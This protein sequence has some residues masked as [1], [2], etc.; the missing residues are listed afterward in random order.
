M[1]KIS[2][3]EQDLTLVNNSE[4]LTDVVYV[5]GYAITGPVNTPVLC[6]TLSDFQKLFGS[7]PYRFEK[8]ERYSE[9]NIF[10]SK[11]YAPNSFIA[12]KDEY[13][14]SY[15]YATELLNKGLPILFERVMINSENKIAKLELTGNTIQYVQ[16]TPESNYNNELTYYSLVPFTGE[17]FESG[18]NYYV[19]D[20]DVY[21][22]TSD[23]TPQSKVNY[24]SLFENNLVNIT[25]N[26]TYYTINSSN[27]N[28]LDKIDL[29]STFDANTN[30]YIL[31]EDKYTQVAISDLISGNTYYI[32]STISTDSKIIIKA[33]YPGKYGKDIKVVLTKNIDNSYTL[34]A[35][36]NNTV[37]EITFVL[38]DTT[39][40]NYFMNYNNSPL[41][42]ITLE[43]INIS[44]NLIFENI[45]KF[46]N[47][48]TSDFDFT[49]NDLYQKFCGSSLEVSI[50]DKLKDRNAYNVK[51]I[52]T[53]GY[54]SL[55]VDSEVYLSNITYP[56][57]TDTIS[58][59]NLAKALLNIA[60]VRGS[61]A[62]IDHTNYSTRPL[63]GEDSVYYSLN[64]DTKEALT[65]WT[66]AKIKIGQKADLEDCRPS[67]TI[68]SPWY[69]Y[70]SKLFNL[71]IVMPGSFGY[72][73]ALAESIKTNVDWLAIAGV[74]RG[75]V[76]NVKQLTQDITSA[77][78]EEW[79]NEKGISIN[80]IT[81]INPYGYTIWGN[82]TLND[83]KHELVAT[84]F[85]NCRLLITEVKRALYNAA[86][87]YMFEN[88][89]NVLWVNFKSLVEKTLEKMV[90]NNGLQRYSVVK[91]VSKERATLTATVTIWLI[92]PIEK[93][94]LTVNIT[95]SYVNIE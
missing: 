82:R 35:S 8:N 5:P 94:D 59:N 19:L 38:D 24:F 87:K 71:N 12:Q 2:I 65:L 58:G 13:E 7:E 89:N 53:G 55:E 84:S 6:T 57:I 30:Y 43:F 27:T 14:Q 52:T 45:N 69:I 47:Y 68:L 50:F 36:L 75:L 25:T 60:L 74:S 83:N 15:I 9:L 93:F 23:S 66:E 49:L 11:A 31:D 1:P 62:L 95:D 20:N 56:I 76:P 79:S 32:E 33:N 42:L 22:K 78:V 67:G 41:K 73:S 51:F 4:E 40:D 77:V 64:E 72:L 3:Y 44:S 86:I 28:I 85:L 90:A 29:V 91:E 54:P 16:T 39:N 81:Y 80:P 70:T 92:E 63:V 88:D 26:G 18:V 46:L 21:T 37:D 34:I 61:V 17:T 48:T 10:N